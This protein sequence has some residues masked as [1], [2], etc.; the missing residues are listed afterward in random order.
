MSPLPLAAALA[1]AMG[2]LLGVGRLWLRRAR[3]APEAR[4]PAWRASVLS[5]LQAAAGLALYLTLFPPGGAPSAP[6]AGA[7]V[8]ATAGAPLAPPLAPGERLVALPEAPA[9]MRAE[10]APDLA[11]ALR[12]RPEARSLRVIG[13]GL[14]PRDRGAA[15]LA[16]AFEPPAPPPGLV[17]LAAPGPVAPGAAF[18][19]AGE[20][21][22]LP[23]GVLQLI[24]PAGAVAAEARVE[25][26]AA[27][28][29]AGAAKAAGLALF[30]LR[31]R[32]GAGR[33]VERLDIPIDATPRPRP[34]TLLLAGAPGAELKFLR[35]WAEDAGLELALDIDLGG[36]A[37]LGQAS[38]TRAALAELD[39]VVIDNRR[40][41]A[42]AAG[43]RAALLAAVETGLGLVFRL[44]EPPSP[45]MR[46]FWAEL[47]L[48][49]APRS[50]EAAAADA[51]TPNPTPAALAP[52]GPNAIALIE[53]AAAWTPRGEGRIGLVTLADS[54]VLQQTGRAE[55]HGR[56]WGGL[57]SSLARPEAAPVARVEGIARAG[58]R[59]ELCALAGPATATAPDGRTAALQ[60]DPASGAQAC[61]GYWP[62]YPGW[63]VVRSGA[64][65]RFVYVHPA[66]AAPSLT[67]AEATAATLAL[68]GEGKA[69]A[70]AGAR[71]GGSPW[72]SF[73]LLL[74]LLA[75]LWGLER[76]KLNPG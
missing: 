49:L 22:G 8:V 16:I 20:I 21:G 6:F 9:A 61:A 39:L 1:I 32:D 68:A 66:G 25:A 56:L 36:G 10:R 34:R 14:S 37:G 59:L 44:A 69:R 19:V 5:A 26:G 76:A 58:R 17:R 40:W 65:E 24:D 45:G 13:E 50:P 35:R 28:R 3:T 73:A 12:Q 54:Y 48:A 7:L 11:A 51:A 75:A 71:Q 72:P 63:H 47:G 42:L 38:L 29:L 4:G 55:E 53:G 27:F 33:T 60:I 67:A 23:A 43:E 2:A 64:G 15:R 46:Q 52:A 70:A 31:L 18:E 62:A 57:F 30:E 74:G 41:E